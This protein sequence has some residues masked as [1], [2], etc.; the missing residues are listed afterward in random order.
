MSLHPLALRRNLAAW[1]ATA[2]FVLVLFSLLDGI[3]A[4][5]RKDP[6]LNEVLPG[7]S[8]KLSGPMPRDTERLDEL[9]LRANTPALALKLEEIHSGFWLGGQQWQAEATFAAD[10]PAGDYLVSLSARNE[11]SAKMTQTFTMRIYPSAQ[12]LSD[13]SLSLI[14]SVLGFNP[15]LLALCSLPFGVVFGVAS[16]YLSRTIT[17]DLRGQGISQVFRVQKTPEGL[18]VFFFLGSQNGL[19]TGDELDILHPKTSALLATAPV[20]VLRAEDAEVLLPPGQ[21]VPINS[22]V[23]LR[24]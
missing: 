22:L 24:R 23:R 17:Q 8:I 7:Q 20:D 5:G 6:N 4:G 19:S 9:F 15:F 10:I 11:T 12:A 13:S 18:R 21:S 16:T 1:I 14:T 3:I 2:C